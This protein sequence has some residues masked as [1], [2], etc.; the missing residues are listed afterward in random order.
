[1]GD[2]CAARDRTGGSI[3]VLRGPGAMWSEA[4]AGS[5]EPL[6]LAYGALVVFGAA[7]VRGYTGFGFSL[8]SISALSLFL[9]P[10]SAVPTIFLLATAAGLRLLPEVWGHVH[11]RSIR[12]L[13]LGCL[14]ATP[15]GVW[16]L[17]RVP[18]APMRLA[19]AVFVMGSA[20]L[21]ARGVA[22]TAMPGPAG[23]LATGAAAGLLNGGF[24]MGGPPL[25][26]F[27]LSTPAGIAAGRA[28]IIAFIV[29]TDVMGLGFQASVGLVTADTFRLALWLLP[30]LLLGVW[31]G[32]RAFHRA[33]PARFRVWTLRILMA[34]ALLLGAQ[35]LGGL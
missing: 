34:L 20:L 12:L 3:A 35:A 16:A 1:R 32:S 13:L 14:A 29:A 9:S 4:M 18:S 11:W 27:Y 24:G 2:A 30:S 28:S 22:L 21:L 7:I 23:T 8:L 19:L 15:I 17:A 31:L 25:I 10:A 5:S 6:L 33:D 26:L